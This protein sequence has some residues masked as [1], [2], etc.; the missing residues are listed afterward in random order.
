MRRVLYT[1]LSILLLAASCVRQEH[2]GRDTIALV[3]SIAADNTSPDR[4]ML[5][6]F[7]KPSSAG[8]I[9]VLGASRECALIG[10]TFVE[11]DI[12][13]NV[14]ARSYSDGLKDFAGET[15]A[16]V[17]D[18]TYTPYSEFVDAYTEDA[19]RELSVRLTLSLLR[20]KCN[21]SIY[22][23]EGNAAK[24]PAKM[25]ILADPWM[26]RCGKFDVDTLFSL[27]SCKVPVISPQDLLLDAAFAGEKKYFNVGL[28]CDSLN[29]KSG[30]YGSIFKEKTTQHKIMGARYFEAP[31]SQSETG[32]LE[33]FLDSYIES[34]RT[35]PL[36][37][38]LVDDWSVDLGQMREALSN[39]RDFSKEESMRYGKCISP[40]FVILGSSELTMKECY[41]LLRKL[42][43]F[44][45]RIALP[46]QE[47]Y[48]IMPQPGGEEMQ[49][50]LIPGK[51]V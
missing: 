11:C 24:A 6:G 4:I 51:D 44:T 32:R 30:I 36:D 3:K 48:V 8:N 29:H 1:C 14:R 26:Q 9:F 23:I 2:T 5:E 13:D 41:L 10:R 50:M 22:D 40:D 16:L 19:L 17:D 46:Q 47:Q 18:V 42:S 45:H 25:I 38:L 33:S 12:F 49:Y 35:E 28:M 31:S 27:T 39:I 43:L 15:F 34:G 37:V 20:D 21:M 7:S